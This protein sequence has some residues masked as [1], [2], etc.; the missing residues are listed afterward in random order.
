MLHSQSQIPLL[1]TYQMKVGTLISEVAKTQSGLGKAIKRLMKQDFLTRNMTAN[2]VM[3][4][5]QG[6]VLSI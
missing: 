4:C 6:V 1:V 3:I 5:Q 2:G